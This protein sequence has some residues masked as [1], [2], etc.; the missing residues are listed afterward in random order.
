MLYSVLFYC[1]SLLPV[2]VALIADDEEIAQQLQSYGLPCDSSPSTVVLPAR[3]LSKVYEQLGRN[4]KLQ[5]SGRPNRSIGVIGTS[6]LYRYHQSMFAFVPAFLDQEQFYLCLDIEMMVDMIETELAYLR[7]NWRVD[8]RPTVSLPIT[9]RMLT[10]VSK[11]RYTGAVPLN[12]DFSPIRQ[13][14]EKFKSG[15]ANGVR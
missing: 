11:R 6:K 4:A 12:P 3:R 2:T 15:F 1:F 5:M 8:G 9:R 14:L 13:L 7:A 10:S